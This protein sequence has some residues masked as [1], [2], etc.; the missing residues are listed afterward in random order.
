MA[1]NLQELE[2]HLR[3]EARKAAR[4][5]ASWEAAKESPAPIRNVYDDMWEG[6]EYDSDYSIVR[7][8]IPVAPEEKVVHVGIVEDEEAGVVTRVPV[9]T[10]QPCT[11]VWGI[12]GTCRSA[13]ISIHLWCASCRSNQYRMIFSPTL[14]PAL[15]PDRHLGAVED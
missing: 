4:R 7:D 11:S 9:W 8:G 6:A 3:D 14:N 2:E 10:V 13:K 1:M 5:S 15:R 12:K